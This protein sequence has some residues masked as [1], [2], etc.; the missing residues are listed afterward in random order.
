[1]LDDSWHPASIK[2]AQHGKPRWTVVLP[3]RKETEQ[4]Q[5]AQM[6][7]LNSLQKAATTGDNNERRRASDEST[8]DKTKEYLSNY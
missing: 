5:R 4:S 6:I 7:L 3:A 8:A 2:C 1:M